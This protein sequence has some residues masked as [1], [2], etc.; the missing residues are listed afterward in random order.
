[1]VAEWRALRRGVKRDTVG[2]KDGSLS[3]VHGELV[4]FAIVDVAGFTAYPFNTRFSGQ[5]QAP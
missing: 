1:L 4:C 2:S 3:T 5:Q